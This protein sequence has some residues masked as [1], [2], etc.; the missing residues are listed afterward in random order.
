MQKPTASDPC[1][2]ANL[3]FC[4]PTPDLKVFAFSLAY[5]YDAVSYHL[6]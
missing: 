6:C 2:A 4:A 1:V 5:V 3:K